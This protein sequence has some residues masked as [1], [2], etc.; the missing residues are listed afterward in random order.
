MHAGIRAPYIRRRG[1]LRNDIRC[2][3]ATVTARDIDKIGTQGVIE[4]IKERVG[5][6]EVYISVDIDVLDPAFAPGMT[7]PQQLHSLSPPVRLFRTSS[8]LELSFYSVDSFV[9]VLD[10]QLAQ[11]S[12]AGGRQGN[13]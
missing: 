4:K 3:F 10:Q 5:D 2:G 13:C 9:N 7:F 12:P 11:R 8:P 1:D 6:S